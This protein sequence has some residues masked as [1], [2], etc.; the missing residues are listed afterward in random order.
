[1]GLLS[2]LS[3]IVGGLIGKTVVDKD[4]ARLLIA[5][6]NLAILDYE[7]T[8]LRDRAKIIVAEAGGE[9]WLQRNWRPGTMAVFVFIIANNFV[10][11]P[12]A[13]AFGFDIPALQI[14][15][16]MWNLLSVGLG[17]Y[18]VGR[19]VEKVMQTRSVFEKTKSH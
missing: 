11:V 18:V 14:P 16:D 6:L 8:T 10:L 17:G 3:E 7:A 12:Y 5:E 19:S 15:P 9:S 2:G 1:M 4:Q 13:R